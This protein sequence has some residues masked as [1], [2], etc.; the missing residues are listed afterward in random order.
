MQD[1]QEDCFSLRPSFSLISV[2]SSRSSEQT[3]SRAVLLAA[4][5]SCTPLLVLTYFQDHCS[6][7]RSLFPRTELTLLKNDSGLCFLR[8]DLRCWNKCRFLALSARTESGAESQRTLLDT[9]TVGGI[10]CC[11]C[12]SGASGIF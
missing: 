9:A 8:D 10:C 4:L 12:I 6:P 1:K 5:C 11:N 7:S 3:R 2:S